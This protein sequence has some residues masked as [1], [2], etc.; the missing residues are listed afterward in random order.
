MNWS[1]MPT[2]VHNIPQ[3]T[4]SQ[5]KSKFVIFPFKTNNFGHCKH[6]HSLPCFV[7]PKTGQFFLIF[8]APNPIPQ[9]QYPPLPWCPLHFLSSSG[10]QCPQLWSPWEWISPERGSA[11]K[12]WQSV[13]H[14]NCLI[15]QWKLLIFSDGGNSRFWCACDHQQTGGP[16]W[17]CLEQSI[18]CHSAIVP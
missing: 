14:L 15:V 2:I 3:W 1:Y 18:A 8:S 6:L 7:P 13:Y 9:H 11:H 16:V 10:Y 4:Y 17:N 12:Q 5:T